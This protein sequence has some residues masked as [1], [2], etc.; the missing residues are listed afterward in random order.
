MRVF[1]SINFRKKLPLDFPVKP[2]TE[3]SGLRLYKRVGLWSS[4]AVFITH[5]IIQP[6]DIIPLC[7]P[8]Y[9]HFSLSHVV[10][11]LISIIYPFFKPLRQSRSLTPL[12]TL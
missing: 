9:I 3:N 1:F 11:T 5:H 8:N 2:P 7:A 12:V 4:I 6:T 10:V